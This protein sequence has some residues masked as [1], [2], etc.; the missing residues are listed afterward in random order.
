[1]RDPEKTR[2]T[3]YS[4]VSK[5]LI[6]KHPKMFNIFLA[7]ALICLI[8]MG[9]FL[10]SDILSFKSNTSHKGPFTG[11]DLKVPQ[12]SIKA[13]KTWQE[14]GIR[15]MD[16]F[17]SILGINSLNSAAAKK[18][19]VNSYKARA[20]MAKNRVPK[21]KETNASMKNL[22]HQQ[23]S[24]NSSNSSRAQRLVQS[25]KKAS[26]PIIGSSDLDS[27]SDT[28]VKCWEYNPSK[29]K[30]VAY[31][32]DRADAVPFN[33]IGGN[34][35]Q[36]NDFQ[37]NETQI[38]E[39][40]V[41]DTQV[42]ESQTNEIRM[43]ETR[44]NESRVNDTQI[45]ESQTNESQLT[46]SRINQTQVSES[47]INE[48][49]MNETGTNESRVNDTRIDE[50]QTNESQ[51]TESRINQTQVSESP[52]NETRMN[53]TRTNESRVNDTRIDESQTNESQLTESRINQTQ[54]IE[55]R[56]N[57]TRMNDS[58]IVESLTNESKGNEQQRDS[59]PTSNISNVLPDAKL[60]G[61]ESRSSSYLF[62]S[63]RPNLSFDNPSSGSTDSARP[64]TSSTTSKPTETE[65][66]I[67]SDKNG[68]AVSAPKESDLINDK[69]YIENGTFNLTTNDSAI[70]DK[71]AQNE[72]MLSVQDKRGKLTPIVS[73]VRDDNVSVNNT[74]DK[75][76]NVGSNKINEGFGNLK[77]H[78]NSSESSTRVVLAKNNISNKIQEPNNDLSNNLTK[79]GQSQGR[80]SLSAMSSFNNGTEI[81]QNHA[82]DNSKN[83]I[84]T[85]VSAQSQES[86]KKQTNNGNRFRSL[87]IPTPPWM[88]KK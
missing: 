65:G 59:Y 69:T 4:S 76:S 83:D 54:I 27:G 25:A 70:K 79:T 31:Q 3:I 23:I 74:P 52:I 6:Q 88:K 58:Q 67:A 61:N 34:Q 15:L 53:E 2:S 36:N 85:K 39:S 63:G 77:G 29:D 82:G 73:K 32:A 47:P 18:A 28:P 12:G 35:P 41:N 10:L 64:Q 7:L 87:K 50:S 38:N 57:E 48:T 62:I 71:K 19:A 24:L 8:A 22:N 66:R 60:G 9:A 56:M 49:Q 21:A 26:A 37:M 72:S 20:L 80:S 86:K 30:S 1:M 78:S 84:Y 43:N 46:E 40:R 42:D 11:F 13:I 14:N 55:S 51:L 81:S 5:G 75:S 33:A 68:S 44:T 16:Q 45:D 17:K